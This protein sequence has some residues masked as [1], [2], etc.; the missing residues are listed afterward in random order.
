MCWE[1]NILRL[2]HLAVSPPLGFGMM[3]HPSS[4]DQVMIQP[5][6]IDWMEPSTYV[7]PLNINRIEPSMCL[8]ALNT[9]QAK[10]GFQTKP[11][12]SIS[13]KDDDS[14]ET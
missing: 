6:N 11:M 14:D 7:Q 1:T 13:S 4:L 2:H 10:Y 9:D 8:P 5:K 12:P 3:D